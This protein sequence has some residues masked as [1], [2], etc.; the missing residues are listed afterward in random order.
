MK[1]FIVICFA[2]IAAHSVSHAEVQ[3]EERPGPEQDITNFDITRKGVLFPSPEGM[4]KPGPYYTCLVKMDGVAGFPF[5]YALYFSTDHNKQGG[6]WLY[7]CK[8]IPTESSNWKSYDQAVADGDFDYLKEKPEKNP[9]YS[10]TVQ[11][12]SSETP[13]ANVIDG[14]VY[15]TYHNVL[16]D[17]RGQ[18]TLLATSPDGINFSRINGGQDSVILEGPVNHTGYFRWAPNPF[19]GVKH[20]Y[21]GY[22]LFGG[23]PN[24]RCAMWVSDD[25]IHWKRDQVFRPQEGHAMPEADKLLI[26]HGIDPNSITPLGNGK[27]VALCSGGN[28]AS[29]SMARVVELYEIFL[30]DDGKTLTGESRKVLAKGAAGS[31][32][33]EEASE[34]TTVLIGDTWHLIYV[35]AKNQGKEN[36]VMSATAKLDKTAPAG[37]EL[38]K[39]DQQRHFEAN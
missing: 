18:G 38:S 35:G 3:K 27:Y 21:V 37:S 28:R 30:G 12:Y 32:D 31:D 19:S 24:F 34:P 17:K 23:G 39:A 13:H 6:I 4:P 29:G 9:V 25:A 8:G 10:D 11:G 22:S 2:F 15:M 26:W 20:K 33:A 5:D 1:H 14:K 36:T 7:L 16:K